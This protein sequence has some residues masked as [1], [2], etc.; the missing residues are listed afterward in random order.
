MRA[1]VGSARVTVVVVAPFCLYILIGAELIYKTLE[2][3]ILSL[4][5]GVKACSNLM[6]VVSTIFNHGFFVDFAA[7]ISGVY[8]QS[9]QC[10]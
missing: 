2:K 8:V 6:N 9:Y 10:G 3:S 7:C 1:S 5:V 4:I